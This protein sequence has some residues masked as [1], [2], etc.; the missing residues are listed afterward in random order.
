M[1]AHTIYENAPLGSL[2]RYSDGTLK[3]PA[4][5][6]RKLAAWEHRNGAGRLVRKEPARD[7][8]SL[9]SAA[10][11]TLHEGDFGSGGVVVLTVRRTYSL[12]SDLCFEI[13]ERPAVGA[14]RIL[15]EYGDNT[16]L[17]HLAE[18]H[19]AAER[20][21]TQHHYSNVLLKEVTEDEVGA[22]VVEGRAA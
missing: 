14:V 11:I 22:D 21:L 5:F 15:Q 7:R 10:S 9:T 13:A 4:R 18:S 20:W 3:P 8:P 1:S 2:I 16:E 19:E 12:D 17:L 6:K